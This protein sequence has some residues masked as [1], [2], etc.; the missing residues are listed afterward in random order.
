MPH[1]IPN[2]NHYGEWQVYF[3]E[4]LKDVIADSTRDYLEK[5]DRNDIILGRFKVAL[6]WPAFYI[7]H[8]R[9]N[10]EEANVGG[11]KLHGQFVYDIVVENS[12]SDLDEKER[13]CLNITGDIIAELRAN[14]HLKDI[15]GNWTCRGLD[16]EMLEPVYPLDTTTNDL[17]VQ[18][19]LKVTVYKSMELS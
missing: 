8:A 2:R 14:P 13:D 18:V 3:A 15:N 11:S 9:H 7:I 1:I 5:F 4:R 6:R 19:G 17:Y 16:L 10:V 12:G